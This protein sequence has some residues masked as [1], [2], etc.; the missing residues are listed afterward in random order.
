MGEYVDDKECLLRRLV[1]PSLRRDRNE[2]LSIRQK[3]PTTR[4]NETTPHMKT[5]I[6]FQKPMRE[7]EVARGTQKTARYK[8]RRDL[9]PWRKLQ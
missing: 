5:N 1:L 2:M 8:V 9:R 4:P 6:Q 3:T 7:T